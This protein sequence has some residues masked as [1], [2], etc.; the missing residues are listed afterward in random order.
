MSWTVGGTLNH[1]LGISLHEIT[2]GTVFKKL[3]YNLYF[4]MFANLPLGFPI[5]IQYRQYHAGHHARLGLPCSM[6]RRDRLCDIDIPGVYEGRRYVRGV[7]RKIIWI[8]LYPFITSARPSLTRSIK[9][10]GLTFLN[11]FFCLAVDFVLFYF[12][13][14]KAFLYLLLSTILGM[15]LHPISAHILAEHYVFEKITGPERQDT[16]SYYGWGN[17]L[18]YNVGYHVEH[19]DFPNVPCTRLPKL[20][21]IAPEF[22]EDLPY[23]RSWI[24]ILWTFIC[25]DNMDAHSRTRRTV[26]L[27]QGKDEDLLGDRYELSKLD[28]ARQIP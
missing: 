2:H 11:Y 23:H 13:G 9:N 8:I 26:D 16:Y 4:S 6:K 18:C 20:K 3:K 22:Y 7:L 12:F 1:S 25:D 21:K 27:S 15:G 14:W 24:K 19:H 10:D 17:K 5:A 28:L